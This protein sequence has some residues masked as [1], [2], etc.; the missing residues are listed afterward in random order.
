MTNELV[1]KIG[2]IGFI[3]YLIFLIGLDVYNI[4]RYWRN[5]K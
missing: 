1:M 4:I 5:K 3:I 2:W